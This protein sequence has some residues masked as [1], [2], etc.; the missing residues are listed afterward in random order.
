LALVYNTTTIDLDWY[1][2]RLKAKLR[3]CQHA[4][5]FKITSDASFGKAIQLYKKLGGWGWG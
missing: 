2:I 1:K 3:Y 4:W 5:G